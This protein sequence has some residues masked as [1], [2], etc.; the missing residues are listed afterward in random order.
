LKTEEGWRMYNE[1]HD[2]K[3]IGLNKSQIARRLE[4]SRPTVIKYYDMTPD[5]FAQ[6][7]DNMHTREKNL[8]SFMT[9]Y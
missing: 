6:G 7:L 3:K 5:E 9:K 4:I 2:L 1:I 8:K